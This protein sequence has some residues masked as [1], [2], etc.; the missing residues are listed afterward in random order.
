MTA[1]KMRDHQDCHGYH[2]TDEAN[3]TTVKIPS[4]EERIGVSHHEEVH[5]S[6]AGRFDR[7]EIT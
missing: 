4:D 7:V 5:V 3:A 2:E 6:H 1:L